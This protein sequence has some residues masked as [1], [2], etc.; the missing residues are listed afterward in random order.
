MQVKDASLL[1]FLVDMRGADLEAR[2]MRDD[3]MTMLIAG[4]CW[5]CSLWQEPER[6]GARGGGCWEAARCGTE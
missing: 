5:L 4:Q 2:Q 6:G 3:L 1:R